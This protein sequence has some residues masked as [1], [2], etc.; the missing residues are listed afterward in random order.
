MP[1]TWPDYFAAASLIQQR[2]RGAVH[3][4]AQR[5]VQ[6][7]HTMYTG[8]ATQLWA[9]GGSDFVNG[10][11]AIASPAAIAATTDFITALKQSGPPKLLD[12]RW[13]ERSMDF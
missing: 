11:C 1:R 9:Y 7:W 2:S 12:Q 4:F 13:Y 10:R 5:G 6:V 3:G 8:F